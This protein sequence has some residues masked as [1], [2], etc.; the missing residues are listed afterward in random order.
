[1]APAV[2]SQEELEIR[3]LREEDFD[4]AYTI[5]RQLRDH[6][7]FQ[8]FA[9]RVRHQRRGGYKLFGA[10]ERTHGLRGVIGMRPV[11]TLA[12]GHHLHVDDLVVDVR[13]RR[14]GIGRALMHFA[15][16]WAAA[17]SL[18]TVFLD[19]RED[20]LTFYEA[21]GYTKHTATLLRKRISY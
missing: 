13:F 11:L 21:L 4:E 17:H 6:L 20:I 8:D 2:I 15:E 10:F 5:V 3:E 9:E 14:R 18:E 7:E 19:S 16:Q 12:R 1:M